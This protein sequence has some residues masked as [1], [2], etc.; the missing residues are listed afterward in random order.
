MNALRNVSPVDEIFCEILCAIRAPLVQIQ[1]S[2]RKDRSEN[3]TV[4][5]HENRDS[6]KKLT[7][8]LDENLK[9]Q[10]RY[11]LVRHVKPTKKPLEHWH[12]CTDRAAK[13][14]RKKV[15]TYSVYIQLAEKVNDSIGASTELGQSSIGPS[16]NS[17]HL[18]PLK[19]GE[20][21]LRDCR[22]RWGSVCCQ[23][24][25]F[26]CLQSESGPMFRIIYQK[27]IERFDRCVLCGVLCR[28]TED[29]NL[30]VAH[31]RSTKSDQ[32]V[33][34]NENQLAPALDYFLC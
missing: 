5:P 29:R 28:S 6:F 23:N 27:A 12:W 26:E 31:V 10:N 24:D 20:E 7:H 11:R 15:D 2:V 13:M 8:T 34:A 25:E 18:G 22:K 14:P 30:C 32:E 17:V 3:C 19:F 9:Y 21:H 33:C 4:L 1:N 16:A